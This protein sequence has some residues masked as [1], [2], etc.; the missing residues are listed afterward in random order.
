MQILKSHSQIKKI[1]HN[2]KHAF[3][4]REGIWEL[5]APQR[6][7]VMSANEIEVH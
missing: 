7:A 3:K 1:P 2:T 6:K 5:D 4:K